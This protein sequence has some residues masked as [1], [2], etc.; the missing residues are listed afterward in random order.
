MEYQIGFMTGTFTFG[1]GK[2]PLM[3]EAIEKGKFTGV[4]FRDAHIDGFI[5]EGNP[6]AEIG[7]LLKHRGLQPISISAIRDWQHRGGW[8]QEDYIESVRG[9][10]QK[11]VA[12]GCDCMVACAFAEDRN[13][14]RDTRNFIELCR[15]GKKYGVRIAL[16]FLPWAGIN[17]VLSA[18]QVVRD[19]NCAN[20]G[21]LVDS[22]HF[23]KGGSRI[24]DLRKVPTEKIFLVH[25]NDAPE[26][27]TDIKDMCMN[28]RLF[29]GDG[30][31]SF[32]LKEFLDELII[33]KKYAGWLVLEVLRKENEKSS[34]LDICKTGM[35]SMRK[36]LEF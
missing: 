24:Q 3:L 11:A 21:L 26:S 17:D 23:F 19:A 9:C 33:E 14:E 6:P 1:G 13:P 28:H 32:P 10:F 18:W 27:G 29:P 2:L 8:G 5:S 36:I 25:L 16:E 20:G 30:M 22:F 12:I 31:G 35:D 34:Y 15:E 4:D 7:R